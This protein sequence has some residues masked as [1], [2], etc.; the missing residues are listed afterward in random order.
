MRLS[1][2]IPI[3][4]VLLISSA[5][6]HDTWLVASKNVVTL[7]EP[8]RIALATGEVFPT[9]EAAAK[10]ERVAGFVAAHGEASRKIEGYAVEGNDLAATVSF[11]QPGAHIVGISLHANF[12][13]LEPQHFEEYLVDE[14]ATDA[15]EKW[16][17]R[18]N[19]A[20]PARELY[21]KHAKTLIEVGNSPTAGGFARPLGH[22][23]EIVPLNEAFA[24]SV[25]SAQ[26]FRVLFEGKP[27]AGVRVSAG[28]EGLPAHTFVEHAMTN[29][30]GEVTFKLG[31][32]G[33]WFLR[34]HV[35][36]PLPE[37]EAGPTDPQ[38]RKADW[39]S[40]WASVTFR[41]R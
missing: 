11:D 18:E 30:D 39:E 29:A 3:L 36:R 10:P 40:F 19:P 5:A 21:T 13:E 20:Q 16:R 37:P 22:T 33:L 32:A 23:L 41:V 14:G 24:C 28:H 17:K 8:V 1:H 25:G 9:S 2:G 38:G 4:S 15:L 34:T 26:R 12:I 35:I 7:N 31:R 27:A 6:A